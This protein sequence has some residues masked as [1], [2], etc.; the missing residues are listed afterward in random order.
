MIGALTSTLPSDLVTLIIGAMAVLTRLSGM[1]F[2]LP[3]VGELS[4]PIRVRMALVLALTAALT[5]MVVPIQFA[6]IDNTDLI[7]LLGFEGLIGVALGM[8]FRLLILALSVAGVVIAQSMS[9]SQI[10]GAGV[11]AEPNPSISLL[12]VMTGAAL[13]VT[14]DLHTM[15]LGLLLDSFAIYP[16]G[17][18]P[19]R[20]GL[21]EWMVDRTA[22]SFALAISLSLPFVLIGFLYN[23]VL[24]MM[25]QAMPQMMVTFI[26][27]PVNVLAGMIILALAITTMMMVWLDAAEVAFNGFW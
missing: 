9:L 20:G 22:S 17:Q 10:F 18:L 11:M 26:G 13:F 1:I 23:V 6:A 16:L 24:G 14:L 12:L 2:L 21:A 4:V 8:S 5:P 27:V 15:S 25:N 3:G 19:P 7:V